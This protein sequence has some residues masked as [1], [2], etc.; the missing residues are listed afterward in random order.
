M[1]KT[2]K[3]LSIEKYFSNN[4]KRMLLV[5]T[6]WILGIVLL[7]VS[8]SIMVSIEENVIKSWAVPFEKF[9]VVVPGT[10]YEDTDIVSLEKIFITGSTGRISTFAFFSTP[11]GINKII[12]ANDIRL[13][14]G[15]LPTQG[16]MEIAVHK[17]IARNQ[18][19]K[20]GDIIGEEKNKNDSLGG[21]FKITSIINSKG[22]LSLGSIEGLEKINDKMNI[23]RLIEDVNINKIHSQDK[24]YSYDTELNDINEYGQILNISMS[25]LLII[26]T[27]ISMITIS[28]ILYIFYMQRVNE[29]GVL[30]AVGYSRKYLINR[31]LKEIMLI[32]LNS[33]I[34]GVIFGVAIN[35]LLDTTLFSPMGQSLTIFKISYLI[36]PLIM[37]VFIYICASIPITRMIEKINPIS[38]IEGGDI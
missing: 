4:R 7:F 20:I 16:S 2:N 18:G 33:I 19:W 29:F 9:S 36:E 1:K 3:P 31:T 6:V 14:D 22:V 24:L 13:I 34:M 21:P 25:V 30:M 10:S 37:I 38:V 8:K 17:D 32:S 26:I 27:I 5:L 35:V 15:N 28:F 23:G 11:E 12:E